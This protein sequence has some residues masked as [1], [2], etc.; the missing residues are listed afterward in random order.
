M[1]RLLLTFTVLLVGCQYMT[2]NSNEIQID[3]PEG[4]VFATDTAGSTAPQDITDENERLRQ[5]I[6][7]M[8][9]DR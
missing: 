9:D 6:Q 5:Y 8:E 2:D 4:E 7:Q 1:A 3:T